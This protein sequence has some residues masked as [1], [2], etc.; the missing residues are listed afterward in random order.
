MKIINAITV[1]FFA[2][3]LYFLGNWIYQKYR[4][5]QFYEYERKLDIENERRKSLSSEEKDSE[6]KLRQSECVKGNRG[7]R[8]KSDDLKVK[9]WDYQDKDFNHINEKVYEHCKNVSFS[10]WFISFDCQKKHVEFFGEYEVGSWCTALSR[11]SM[12]NLKDVFKNTHPLAP[13]ST[14][15]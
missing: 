10:G 5:E 8:L 7:V 1:L 11:K 4:I 9:I 15:F 13:S 14:A 12:E 3:S 6:D 2:L